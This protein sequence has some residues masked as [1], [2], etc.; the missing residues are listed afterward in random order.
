VMFR[1]DTRQSRLFL[2]IEFVRHLH[3]SVTCHVAS[4]SFRCTAISRISE[5][6]STLEPLCTHTS[7]DKSQG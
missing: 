7:N 6:N 1:R 3:P 2:H 4:V 5:A